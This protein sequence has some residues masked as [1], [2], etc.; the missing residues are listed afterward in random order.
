MSQ[1]EAQDL[2]ENIKN[3]IDLNVNSNESVQM[4]T[5]KFLIKSTQKAF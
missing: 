3:F 2:Y 4:K 5:G 1:Q